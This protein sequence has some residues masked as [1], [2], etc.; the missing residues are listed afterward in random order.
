ME[1]KEV[2][3]GS[4]TEFKLNVTETIKKIIGAELVQSATTTVMFIEDFEDL[5]EKKKI[6]L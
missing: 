1:I 6:K 5:S 3:N 2:K 4:F